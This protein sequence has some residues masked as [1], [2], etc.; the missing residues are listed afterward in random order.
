MEASLA[1]GTSVLVFR[2][3]VEI[4]AL[5]L[6][7]FAALATGISEAPLVDWDEATY[8][9]V[10][11]EA[12]Q[13]GSYLNFTWNGAPYLKKPPLLF[14]M[15][16]GSF[17]TFGESA[18]AARLPSV[19]A[20]LGTLLL[21]YFFASPIG[22]RLGGVFAAIL[23]LGFY[24]FVARGGR[25]CAT[26]S[27]LLF[28][29]VLGLLAFTR[30]LTSY[31]WL[32]LAGLSCGLAILSKGAAGFVPLGVIWLAVL[33]IPRFSSIGWKGFALVSAAAALFAAPW[34]LYQILNNGSLFWSVFVKHETL[35]RVSSHLEATRA[36]STLTTFAREVSYLWVL[37]IPF[38]GLLASAFGS[39]SRWSLREVPPNVLLWI[40]W[41][42]LALTAACAV[43][44]KLGWYILPA[45][46]PV[47]LL[48]GSILG[49]SFRVGGLGR[50]YCPALATLAIA[51][52]LFE[53][54]GHWR[55]I[56]QAFRTQR[57]RSRPAY[58]L[59]KRAHQLGAANQVTDLYFIGQELPTLVYYSGM[60]SHFI[61]PS[62]GSG[63]ELLDLGGMSLLVEDRQV[64][65]LKSNGRPAM[66][67]N[68]GDE[69]N[70]SGP[71]EERQ[72]V[73]SAAAEA[74][75]VVN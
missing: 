4:I 63:F 56:N 53:A 8:A 50:A 26:D 19:I 75:I 64:L 24:F 55:Q 1:N 72:D 74:D 62:S 13:T 9:E 11:H 16:I 69:W 17:K 35:M 12:I 37:L 28:F 34:F 58:T 51:I 10:A 60:R 30:G 66:V 33:L 48:G 42:I 44:T 38:G 5:V 43:Q 67:G 70:F 52:L 57:E 32:L 29:S 41:L 31:R 18:W 54:P 68:I 47:A 73:V 6:L 23:P 2:F 20:G 3:R 49:Q 65:L 40:L 25:E 7:G 71:L 22:G 45:L 39:G 15:M 27:L 46:I 59:G 14:W 61:D 21:L 36:D